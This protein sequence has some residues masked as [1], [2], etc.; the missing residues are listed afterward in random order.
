MVEQTV[1]IQEVTPFDVIHSRLLQLRETETNFRQEI[2]TILNSET[3]Q[4][5]LKKEYRTNFEHLLEEE[6]VYFSHETYH[7]DNLQILFK[8]MELY[9]AVI[10]RNYF[11]VKKEFLD[12]LAKIETQ[13]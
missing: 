11:R 12:F 3:F 1:F 9:L 13:E 8:N 7:D 4:P 10:S 6:R 2:K 5:D